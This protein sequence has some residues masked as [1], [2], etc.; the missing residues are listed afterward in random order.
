MRTWISAF[1]Q[2][3]KSKLTKF[4]W[5]LC[6]QNWDK[7]QSDVKVR[8]YNSESMMFIINGTQIDITRL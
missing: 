7:M 3:I 4:K 5:Y 1:Y 6:S 2:A 8:C